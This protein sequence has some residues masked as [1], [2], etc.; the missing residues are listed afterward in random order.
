MSTYSLVAAALLTLPLLAACSAAE[1]PARAPADARARTRAPTAAELDAVDATHDG[2]T[3]NPYHAI[4]RGKVLRAFR[5]LTAHDP[6]PA[7]ATMANDVHY[8]F[9]GE[10]HALAG[11]RVTRAGVEKWFG[12][13]FRLLPGA[14]VIRSVEVTGFPWSTRVV[15]TF[16]HEVT[17]PHE[18]PYLGEGVQIVELSW[19]EAKTIRTYVD[20][21]RLV[22]TLDAMA[23]EGVAEAKAAPILE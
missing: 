7:L 16:A 22:R 18:P 9:E 19:G 12:R 10:G 4:V 20:T 23:A 1:R 3:L 14:F 13:L 17:P 11:T 21:D 6:A 2:V 5:G 8:T 15:T